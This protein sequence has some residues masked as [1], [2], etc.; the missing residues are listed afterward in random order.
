M[1]ATGAGMAPGK[2]GYLVAI[3]TACHGAPAA[4]ARARVVIEE[5][6]A[7]RIRADAQAGR[8]ALGNEFGCGASHGGEE[9]FEP[10]FAGHEF[11]KPLAALQDELVVAFGDA[12][13]VVDGFDPIARGWFTAHHGVERF[14]HGG[15]EPSGFRQE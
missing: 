9:P 13:N 12:Q 14:E 15:V 3:A 7:G 8:G 4:A 6:A 1:L 2:G 5:Q 10:F 11:Q